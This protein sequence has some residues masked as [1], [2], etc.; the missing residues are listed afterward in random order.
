MPAPLAATR[1]T[2]HS[3]RRS[4]ISGSSRLYMQALPQQRTLSASP[5][6]LTP[7]IFAVSSGSRP[8]PLEEAVGH[9]GRKQRLRVGPAAAER[10]VGQLDQPHPGDLREE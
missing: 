4:A 3:R 10:A 7:G 5:T 9:L 1:W 6:S 8:L 2:F